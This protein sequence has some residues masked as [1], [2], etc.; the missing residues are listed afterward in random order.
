MKI[1]S[2][3]VYSPHEE[4]NASSVAHAP[5]YPRGGA[6]RRA[7]SGTAVK[8]GSANVRIN[9]GVAER[10]VSL[11]GGSALIAAGLLRRSWSGALL[12]LGG[13]ALLLRGVSGMCPLYR[14]LGI[15]TARRI[16][17]QRGV[18][19]IKIEKS[20]IVNKAPEELYRFWRNLENLPRFMDHLQAVRV[21]DERRSHWIAEAPAG[22]RM[23][24]DAEIIKEEDG[25]MI[26]W[27]SLE[28]ADVKNAGSVYFEREPG[29]MEAGTRVRVILNYEPPAGRLG[30]TIA[31]LFGEEPSRQIEEDLNRFKQIIEIGVA[32]H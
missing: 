18:K 12:T 24:W 32:Y 23:E 11:L 31:K 17:V 3:Q 15:S 22:I 9:V 28:N 29:E 6:R 5:S 2:W 7:R 19:G 4:G 10:W 13:G 14:T 27:R 30:A 1:M 8:T 25:H 26:A 16:D 20:I 21:I